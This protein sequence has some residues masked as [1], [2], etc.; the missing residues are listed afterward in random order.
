MSRRLFEL[1]CLAVLL[2]APAFAQKVYTNEDLPERTRPKTKVYT[3]KDAVKAAET[4][5][6]TGRKKSDTFTTEDLKRMFPGMETDADEAAADEKTAGESAI[7]SPPPMTTTPADPAATARAKEKTLA[8][9]RR[10]ALEVQN[11][12]EQSRARIEHLEKELHAVNN[13]YAPRPPLTDEEKAYRQTHQ[14]SGIERRSRITRM[15][16]DER[17]RVVALERKLADL[18]P[19]R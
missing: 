14:E 15:L 11:D 1:A 12:L 2:A 13:P 10:Q 17:A 19:D 8:E 16:E 7:P 3:N 4:E 9:Q 5:A 18:T 6:D